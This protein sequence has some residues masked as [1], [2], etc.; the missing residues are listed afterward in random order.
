MNALKNWKIHLVSI[1]GITA[2]WVL[3]SLAF[4]AISGD[5]KE[6]FFKAVTWIFIFFVAPVF[7]APIIC[8]ILKTGNYYIFTLCFY[9][10]GLAII[11]FVHKV[12]SPVENADQVIVCF[13]VSF[14]VCY[15]AYKI[16]ELKNKVA[17]LMAYK[18]TAEPYM[19]F[20]KQ[21]AD[22]CGMGMYNYLEALKEFEKEHGE[23]C[24]KA[25]KSNSG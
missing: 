9:Y 17:E 20:F 2:F 19:D 4:A 11:A 22:K 23:S 12:I 13:L 21:K 5:F 10:G 3:F 14:V 18:N 25:D 24:E 7:I 16:I 15:V 1:L 6:N 8:F